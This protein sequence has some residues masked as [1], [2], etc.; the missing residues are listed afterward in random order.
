MRRGGKEGEWSSS[1]PPP[2]QSPASPRPTQQT[3][4]EIAEIAELSLGKRGETESQKWFKL[5]VAPAAEELRVIT[6]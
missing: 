3:P 1:S 5:S 2:P 6:R 4:A